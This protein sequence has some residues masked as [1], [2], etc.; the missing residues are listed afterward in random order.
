VAGPALARAGLGNTG[1]DFHG[2]PDT[3]VPYH[4]GRLLFAL[5]AAGL[6]ARMISFP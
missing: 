4:R 6:D 3:L 1:G 5:T 2:E